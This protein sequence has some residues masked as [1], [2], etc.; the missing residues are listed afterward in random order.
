[1]IKLKSCPFCGGEAEIRHKVDSI[2]GDNY[3]ARCKRTACLGRSYK[4]WAT[5]EAA[6]NAWNRRAD[7]G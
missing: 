3:I 6:A 2:I 5:A 4:K 1:M 7:N